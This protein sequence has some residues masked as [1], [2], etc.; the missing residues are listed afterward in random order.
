MR[1]NYA[2]SL[3]LAGKYDDA[4]DILQSLVQVPDAEERMRQNLALVYG[5]E[6]NDGQ[7]AHF[8]RMDLDE[9]AVNNNLKYYQAMRNLDSPTAR[10]ADL[11]K[12]PADDLAPTPAQPGKTA[13]NGSSQA[14]PAESVN[15]AP[16]GW[17]SA[18][19]KTVRAGTRQPK[20]VANLREL[21]M[22]RAQAAAQASDQSDVVARNEPAQNHDAQIFDEAPSGLTG[23]IGPTTDASPTDA[24]ASTHASERK[25]A[26]QK[27]IALASPAPQAVAKPAK[28]SAHQAANGSTAKEPAAQQSAHRR[29]PAVPPV[30]PLASRALDAP[31][32]ATHHM[33]D[34]DAKQPAGKTGSISGAIESNPVDTGA[35]A[36]AVPALL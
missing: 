15:A 14:E 1:N 28:R 34:R 24:P 29:L 35:R 7:A 19:A 11:T 8:G 23:S 25:A 31:A 20:I 13:L 9:D 27:Q 21:P 32:P 10:A 6:G 5:L 33:T 3:A 18:Q 17:Q 30:G 16:M 26:E 12:P 4:T 36:P 22:T 2:L